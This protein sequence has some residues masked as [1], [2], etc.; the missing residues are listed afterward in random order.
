MTISA[1]LDVLALTRTSTAFAELHPEQ[2]VDEAIDSLRSQDLRDRIVYLYVVD[3]DRRLHGVVSTRHLLTAAR[4]DIVRT[5]MR[6]NVGTL[7]GTATLRDAANAFVT[8]GL[9]ALPVVGS[10]G[11]MLGVVDVAALGVDTAAAADRR[12][13][14][15]V[16]QM[17]GMHA[18]AAG[19]RSAAG[20]RFRALAWTIAGGIVAATITAAHADLVAAVM[21]LALFMPVA[22]ALSE[23]IGM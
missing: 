11:R 2:T 21:A 1:D 20:E 5:L 10:L 19:Q 6:T 16:F 23:S 14:D 4:S 18:S 15:E 13:A 12:H 9:L 8:H 7:P 3:D 22:L 17:L